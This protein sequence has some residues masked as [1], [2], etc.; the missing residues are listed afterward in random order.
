MNSV[1]WRVVVR[2][3]MGWSSI[4]FLICII[5]VPIA[6]FT[7]LLFFTKT[8]SITAITIV[9]AK[10]NTESTVRSIAEKTLGSNVLFAQTKPIERAIL[11]QVTQVRDVHIIRKLPGT[12]K[13]IIQEKTPVFLLLSGGTYYFVDDKGIAYEE[14]SL[15][16]LPGV[17]LPVVKNSDKNAHVTLGAQA[18]DDQFIGFITEALK[19]IPD[20]TSS[21]VV[22]IQIPSLE[23]REAHFLLDKNWTLLMDT[24]RSADDQLD[25]LKRLL[26]NTITA[27]EQQTLQYVDLRIPNRVYYK[28]RLSS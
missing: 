5:I 16:V 3:L 12:L 17:V 26:E 14:A 8:F 2:R 6:I 27:Q 25:I 21:Q 18:V 9:D 10:P 22:E 19:K 1:R 7:W 23:T 28:S 24:T 15:D 20:S 13:I 4:A 11:Q